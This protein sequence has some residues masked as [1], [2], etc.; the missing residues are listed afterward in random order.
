MR[1][2]GMAAH[3]SG[4]GGDAGDIGGWSNRHTHTHER[5]R[6]NTA[7][8]HTE[9]HMCATTDGATYQPDHLGGHT[10]WGMGP[11]GGGGGGGVARSAISEPHR[12]L[13]PCGR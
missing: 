8:P 9:H 13:V 2:K 5:T 6:H 4:G 10:G 1:T 3:P 12:R 11:C 7:T